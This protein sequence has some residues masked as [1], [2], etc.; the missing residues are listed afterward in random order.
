MKIILIGSSGLLANS[1]GKFCNTQNIEIDAW[2]SGNKINYLYNKFHQIDLLHENIDYNAIASAD[3]IFYVAGAGIQSNLNELSDVIYYLNTFVPIKLFKELTSIKFKGNFIT[4]GSYFEFGENER[5]F[6]ITENDIIYSTN[7]VPNDYCIS[8]RL[9][10]RFITSYITEIQHL[11]FILPTIYGENENSNRL[12][13]YIINAVKNKSEI[14]LTS[15]EQVRQ[16]IY[17]DDIPPILFKVL[18]QKINPG[19]YNIAGNENF[20]IKDLVDYILKYF[21]YSI[22]NASFGSTTKSDTK[23][24]ILKLDDSKLKKYLKLNPRT[25]IVDVLSKY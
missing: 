15:G 6:F 10:T 12:I 2:G 17:V 11:H 5:D 13:P 7:P 3:I 18:E 22:K 16:Y 1:I 25:N 21:N 8:K 24:K 23:M 19:V 20:I 14:K 9:L 4:F